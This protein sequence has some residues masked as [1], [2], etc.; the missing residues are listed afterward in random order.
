MIGNRHRLVLLSVIAP[1]SVA[2]G[3]QVF[4]H[5]GRGRTASAFRSRPARCRAV[6]NVILSVDKS[7]PTAAVRHTS[8]NR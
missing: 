4:G 7:T 3:A 5:P 2:V 6:L 8:S 1:A